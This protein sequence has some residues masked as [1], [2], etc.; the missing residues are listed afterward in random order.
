[1]EA[2]CF[3]QT[4]ILCYKS[5]RRHNPED[6]PDIFTVARN[7][8]LITYEL[9]VILPTLQHLHVSVTAQEMILHCLSVINDETRLKPRL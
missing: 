7:S 2:V 3:S 5:T 4:V 9:F 8:N 1:M 6:H